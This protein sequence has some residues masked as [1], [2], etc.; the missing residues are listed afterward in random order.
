MTPD[1][2]WEGAAPVT[3]DEALDRQLVD[4]QR[5]LYGA[6]KLCKPV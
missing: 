6:D 1:V 5:A 3:Y 2:M 4:A